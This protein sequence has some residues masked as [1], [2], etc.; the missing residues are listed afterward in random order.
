MSHNRQILRQFP[1][2]RPELPDGIKKI[3]EVHYKS[4]RRGDS[5]ATGIS[6]K[7]EAWMH[8]RVA[9]DTFQNFNGDTL[10]IGAGTLNQLDYERNFAKYDVVEPMSYLYEDSPHKNRILHFYRDL[11][12]IPE[13]TKYDRITSIAVFEHICELPDV[14]ARAAFFLKPEGHL[15][16]AI[17]AEGSLPWY[18]G[19]RFF[20]GLEFYLKYRL[21]YKH[22]MHF[23]HVNGWRDILSVLRCFF[24]N[25]KAEYFGFGPHL[26]FYHFYDCS[27]PDLK[28]AAS[29]LAER[30]GQ[31]S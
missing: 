11:I 13:G 27:R 26:S 4:N 18:L 25:I 5:K 14:V 1:K 10:E 23:E 19:W 3:Y 8:R 12:N 7:M 17:P 22:L 28:A 29:H 15:R 6:Q 9:A 24:F 2:T 20:T 31:K 30:S 16:V 21:N